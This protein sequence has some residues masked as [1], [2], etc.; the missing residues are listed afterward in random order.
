M[1]YFRITRHF[2]ELYMEKCT[3][4]QVAKFIQEIADE[5]V[6]YDDSD[7]HSYLS[8]T[9]N[10]SNLDEWP[11]NTTVIIKGEVIVPKKVEVI[12]KFEIE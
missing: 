7:K 4:E 5:E 9:S 6:G 8:S 11:V 12:T 2:D 10:V 1:I 3:K